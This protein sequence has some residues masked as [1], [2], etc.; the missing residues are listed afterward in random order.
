MAYSLRLAHD[1]NRI[2]IMMDDLTLA[3]LGFLVCYAIAYQS[4]GISSDRRK[5][6]KEIKL[7]IEA[8]KNYARCSRCTKWTELQ[9]ASMF[10]DLGVFCAS[11]SKVILLEPSFTAPIATTSAKKKSSGFMSFI[12]GNQDEY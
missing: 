11:C 5:I 1:G 2:D 7:M 3:M 4:Y 10:K 6:K 8:G 12:K 9:A